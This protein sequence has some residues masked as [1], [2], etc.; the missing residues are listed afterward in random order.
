[1]AVNLP[2]HDFAACDSII[3]AFDGFS[4]DSAPGESFATRYGITQMT[5]DWAVQQGVVPNIPLDQ[6]D[7]VQFT[8]IRK[9]MFWNSVHGSQL[10]PGVNLMVYNDSVLTGAG[11]AVRLLQR[12]VGVPDDGAIGPYTL[13]RVAG[14]RPGDLIDTLAKADTVYLSSL[15]KAPL[16]L[17]GW[18][19]RESV[20]TVDA[21]AMIGG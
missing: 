3:L 21:H 11:H 2:P 18:L 5:W 7:V 10:P 14:W 15:A 6:G 19:R 9:V 20:M 8:N 16:Y 4:N 12:C 1:M 13:S 17:R